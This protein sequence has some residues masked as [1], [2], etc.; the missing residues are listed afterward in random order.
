MSAQV[1]EVFS[2]NRISSNLE[3]DEGVESI[4]DLLNLI[5][6][7]CVVDLIPSLWNSGS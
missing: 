1:V 2:K 4:A 6:V 5:S 3:S 7:A